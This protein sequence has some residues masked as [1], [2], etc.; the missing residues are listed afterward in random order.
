MAEINSLEEKGPPA[1]ADGQGQG[2]AG[3]AAEDGQAPAPKKPR[4]GV[5]L[6]EED[7]LADFLEVGRRG[8]G[9]PDTAEIMS[10]SLKASVLQGTGRSPW[11]TAWRCAGEG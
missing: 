10:P 6:D 4:R 7:H 9:F 3:K 2:K 11:Q 1:G 5:Q 8:F